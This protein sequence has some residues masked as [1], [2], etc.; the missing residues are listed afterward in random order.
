MSNVFEQLGY[1]K[2]ENKPSYKTFGL[3]KV[4]DGLWTVVEV[5]MKGAFISKIKHLI[6]PTAKS[7]A[8]EKY[9][10]EIA[11]QFLEGFNE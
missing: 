3:V 8:V 2:A 11:R 9:K 7:L 5:E 6:T 4:K 1:T 10:R